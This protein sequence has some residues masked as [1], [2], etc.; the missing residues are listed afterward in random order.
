MVWKKKL[1]VRQEGYLEISTHRMGAIIGPPG[2]SF[3]INI[4]EML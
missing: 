2:E 4:C 1:L 3:F